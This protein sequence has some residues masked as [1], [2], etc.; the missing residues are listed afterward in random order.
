MGCSRAVGVWLAMS[1]LCRVA[2]ADDP[3]PE[4]EKLFRDG[5]ALIKEGKVAAACDAFSASSKLGPSVGAFLN[6]GDCRVRLGQ[7][8]RAWAAFVEAGRLAGKLADP[9]KA[10]ADR[11]AGELEPQ[12]SYLELDVTAPRPGEVIARDGIAIDAAEWGNAAPVDPGTHRITTTAPDAE[13][14][15]VTVVVN[16]GGDH[17][18]VRVPAL[19]AR[20]IVVPPPAP[21]PTLDA[22]RDVAI[23]VAGAGAI[24]GTVAIVLVAQAKSLDD[25]ARLTCSTSMPCHDATAAS[26]SARAVRLANAATFVGTGAVAAVAAGAVLWFVGRPRATERLRVTATSSSLSFAVGGVF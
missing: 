1:S 2:A 6:L 15:S 24:A 17:Q 8:A 21:L 14:W 11:R 7:T 12:L 4:A 13:P 18:V 25:T 23:G 10:E 26:D 22:T 19:H 5:R 20:P 9:R 3:N 16:P